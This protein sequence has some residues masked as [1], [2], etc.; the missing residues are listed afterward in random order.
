MRTSPCLLV[1]RTQDSGVLAEEAVDGVSKGNT[2]K[3]NKIPH[4]EGLTFKDHVR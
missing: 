2:E 3:K 4:E 1:K